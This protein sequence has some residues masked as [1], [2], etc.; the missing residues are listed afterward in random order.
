MNPIGWISN[1]P[2]YRVSHCGIDLAHGADTSQCR[3]AIPFTE[4][5]ITMFQPKFTAVSPMRQL[6]TSQSATN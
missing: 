3:P 2:G 6:A 1:M 4:P 5:D